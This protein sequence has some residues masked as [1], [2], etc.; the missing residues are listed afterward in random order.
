MMPPRDLEAYREKLHREI[1]TDDRDAAIYAEKAV[2]LRRSAEL[3]R[4]ELAGIDRAIEA[5]RRPTYAN[6]LVPRRF[7]PLLQDVAVPDQMVT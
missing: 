4:A 7:G 5:F 6:R 2:E 3:L 1:E